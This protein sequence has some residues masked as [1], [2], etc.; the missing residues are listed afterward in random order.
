MNLFGIITPKKI[1]IP[2]K[3]SCVVDWNVIN[4]FSS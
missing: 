1:N 2:L 4:Y 3:K